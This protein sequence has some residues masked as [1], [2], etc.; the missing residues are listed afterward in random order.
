MKVWFLILFK[1]VQ[2]P[3]KS[4]HCDPTFYIRTICLCCFSNGSICLLPC[5]GQSMDYNRNGWKKKLQLRLE[6]VTTSIT[7]Y[8]YL[9]SSHSNI[10]TF[11][12][13]KTTTL[14]PFLS[15]IRVWR[16]CSQLVLNHIL[17]LLM[18]NED[19]AFISWY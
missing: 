4:L 9:Y 6:I 18:R 10:I 13:K 19:M 12:P 1:S 17:V 8:R 11:P 7:I 5:L 15:F 3:L 16:S 2:Y 14:C